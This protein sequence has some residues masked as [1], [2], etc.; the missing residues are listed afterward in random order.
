ME[1]TSCSV[2]I[3][4]IRVIRGQEIRG[5]KK[6]TNHMKIN[7][8]GKAD[9]VLDEVAYWP[10]PPPM[11]TQGGWP[12]TFEL[13]A[14]VRDKRTHDRYGQ[15]VGPS[16]VEGLWVV[17]FAHGG[18]VAPHE[19]DLEPFTPSGAE[20]EAIRQA[21]KKFDLAVA[22]DRRRRPHLYQ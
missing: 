7:L 6:H 11:N 15:I 2:D 18:R 19:N 9:I 22:E 4:A 10:S 1:G 8:T 21:F 14:F 3:R 17:Q 20:H 16:D 13:G 12:F 5:S